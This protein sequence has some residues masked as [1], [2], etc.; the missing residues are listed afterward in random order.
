M[1][2]FEQGTSGIDGALNTQSLGAAA[3][4]R[5]HVFNSRTAVFDE[6][7][8]YLSFWKNNIKLASTAKVTD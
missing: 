6:K 3:V 7:Y 2:I 1:I 4:S 8:L 5:W